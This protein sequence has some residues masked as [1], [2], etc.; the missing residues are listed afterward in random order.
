MRTTACASQDLR[1]IHDA[2]WCALDGRSRLSVA[3]QPLHIF[4]SLR[5]RNVETCERGPRGR[6]SR[7]IVIDRFRNRGYQSRLADYQIRVTSVGPPRGTS[8]SLALLRN[9]QFSLVL[10]PLRRAWGSIAR[11][12][13]TLSAGLYAQDW[14]KKKKKKK[15]Q[16]SRWWWGMLDYSTTYDTARADKLFAT[17][18]ASPPPSPSVGMKGQRESS[19]KTQCL[20]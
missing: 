4:V 11:C 3:F 7:G 1:R 15:N 5:G 17:H 19:C 12:Q 10:L 20:D 2:G 9:S 8:P 6:V 16:L 18:S 13:S 14:G